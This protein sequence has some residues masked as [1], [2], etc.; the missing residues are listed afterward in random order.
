VIGVTWPVPDEIDDATL[1]RKLFAPAS[2]NPP[3]SKPL[4]D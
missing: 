3:Q 4:P 1:E 2:Y